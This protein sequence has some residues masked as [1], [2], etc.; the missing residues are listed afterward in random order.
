VAE[1]H[2]LILNV[3]DYEAAR[4][5]RSEMLKRAGFQVLDAGSGAQALELATQSHPDLILLDVNLP[6]MDGFEVCRRLRA[7]PMTITVPIVHVSATFTSERAQDLAYEGGADSY[8]TDPVEPAVLLATIHSLLRLR[9]A[10]EGLRAAS[11]GW[12]VTFDA[13]GDG[14]CLLGADGAVVRCNDAFAAFLDVAPADLI[15]RPWADVWRVLGGDPEPSPTDR[16]ERSRRR[17]TFDFQREHAWFRL[18]VDPVLEG[19]TVTGLVCIVSDVTLERQSAEVRAALFAREQEA[20]AE[21]EATN[22]AKDEFLAMLGHELRN[23]LDVIGTAVRV[24]DAQGA[25]DETTAKARGVIARQVRQLSRLVDDLLDVGRVTTGK[26]AL[27]RVPVDLAET[28]QRC[29]AG[30]MPPGETLHHAITMRTEPTWVGAD[31][32]RLEQIVM[33]L[34]SNALKYTPRGGSIEV[35]VGG[36]GRVGRLSVKDS[37][38]GMTP[39]MIDRIFDLFYQGERTLDRAE[40]GLGIGLTLVRRLVE[41]H[42]GRVEAESPGPGHGSTVTVELPQIAAPASSERV[43]EAPPTPSPRRIVIVEDSRDSREMLRYLLEHAGHEVH[44]ASDGPSGLQAIL[45]IRPDIALVD[46]GLPGLDGYEVA[47]KVRTDEAGRAVRLVALTGYG[48]PDDLR[49]SEDA[50]FDAHLVKPVDPARL[51]AVIRGAKRP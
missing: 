49:R 22:R 9:R 20:R 39:Q 50:G 21:A 23:P 41:L 30:L 48:L 12:Q 2:G 27:V 35:M 19:N 1:P 51:A 40:G 11:R 17:E 47:R 38:A 28:A 4:Y 14:I 18:L 15:G 44:E 6:D 34:L 45:K 29:V 32:A 36:D 10:E 31:Q 25:G 26:I 7:D 43:G 8:L 13:I 16:V 46:V 42:G 3:D 37:G 33:N 5:A 24:L